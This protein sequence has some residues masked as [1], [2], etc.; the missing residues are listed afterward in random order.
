MVFTLS[1]AQVYFKLKWNN[2]YDTAKFQKFNH[3]HRTLYTTKP[4]Q[5]YHSITM[6]R[7]QHQIDNHLINSKTR[8]E[9]NNIPWELRKLN[10]DHFKFHHK[11]Y[12][13][14]SKYRPKPSKK[15]VFTPVLQWN[16]WLD[17]LHYI[18]TDCIVYSLTGGI[19]CKKKYIIFIRTYQYYMIQTCQ[20][21]K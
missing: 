9:Y 8:S 6:D 12:Q 11:K 10:I 4:A 18:S 13:L 19:H 2:L 21:I 1:R 7:S 17:W 3:I 14:N 20:W 15:R 16:G 5:L